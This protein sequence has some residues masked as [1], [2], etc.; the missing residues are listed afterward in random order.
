LDDVSDDVLPYFYIIVEIKVMFAIPPLHPCF[1]SKNTKP[2][3]NLSQTK[4]VYA[5]NSINP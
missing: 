4:R 3:R 5:F 1:P 2:G